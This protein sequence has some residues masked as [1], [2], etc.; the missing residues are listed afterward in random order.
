MSIVRSTFRHASVYTIAAVLGKLISFF[1]LPFYTHVLQDVGYG[2]IGMVETGMA[3]LLSLMAYGA[4]GGI[5]RIYHEKEPDAKP[6]VVSTGMI[7]MGGVSPVLTG[8][9]AIFARPLSGLLLESSDQSVLLLM[10]LGGFVLEITGVAAS[11][12]LLIR[13]RS[14]LFSLF[15][16]VRLFLGLGTS[17]WFV[18]VLDWG[19]FG[20]FLSSLVT[21]L[22]AAV[23][24]I[25]IAVR[26]CGFG[27]D[28]EIA[29]ELIAFQLPLVPGNLA[30]FVSRQVERVLVRFQLSLESVG[31]LEIGYKFPV[32][33]GLLISQP[34]MRSWNTTRTEIADEPGAPQRIGRVLPRQIFGLI[35]RLALRKLRDD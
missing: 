31:V 7:L 16:L 21:S 5:I 2:V 4:Q 27:Y 30:S 23:C 3:L 28:R 26:E 25:V 29:R 34:F 13:K 19:L 18:L 20:Y 8:L 11:S 14:V 35:Q 15:G 1:M 32:L 17:I 33:I 9:V 12:I 24:F 6:R 22:V 10:A